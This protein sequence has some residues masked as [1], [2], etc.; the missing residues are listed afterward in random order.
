MP[1]GDQRPGQCQ[2][3]HHGL[4][5]LPMFKQLLKAEFDRC[6]T[7]KFYYKI[8]QQII[9]NTIIQRNTLLQYVSCV[10]LLCKEIHYDIKFKTCR[11]FI[12][13]AGWCY[14]RWSFCFSPPINS[15]GCPRV[16][17]VCGLRL[18]TPPPHNTLPTPD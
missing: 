12:L 5:L 1:V 13:A 18:Y 2:Q 7:G 17:P 14:P 8:H 10:V 4:C 3:I 16:T 9:F 11:Y 15:D 6:A